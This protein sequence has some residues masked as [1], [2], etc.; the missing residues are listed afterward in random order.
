[1]GFPAKRI[2]NNERFHMT[3][4]P[5]CQINIIYDYFDDISRGWETFWQFYL[6][7]LNYDEKAFSLTYEEALSK[8]EKFIRSRLKNSK[9]FGLFFNAKLIGMI[10][11]S[12]RI[13]KALKHKA[14]LNS[15]FV[16]PEYRNRGLGK[17]LLENALSAAKKDVEFLRLYVNSDSA[18][19]HL[20]ESK[21]F[22]KYAV[23]PYSKKFKT[24]YIDEWVMQLDLR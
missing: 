5:D 18:A 7:A 16:L 6:Q 8:E 23:E 21:G 2:N 10:K 20:Y 14:D 12:Y 3:N 24:L 13:G 17:H 22:K 9:V 19:I 15:F 1:M 11:I 4:I